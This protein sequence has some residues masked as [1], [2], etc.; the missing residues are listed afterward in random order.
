MASKFTISEVYQDESNR[1]Q[2][3]NSNPIKDDTLMLVS[4][5][6][7]GTYKTKALD[8]G[9][10][11]SSLCASLGIENIINNTTI[12]NYGDTIGISGDYP[13]FFEMY[14]S[15]HFNSVGEACDFSQTDV[16]Q[17][18]GE[19]KGLYGKAWS[20]DNLWTS[21]GQDDTLANRV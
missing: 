21:V 14:S 1:I 5:N 6:D 17:D 19:T 8:Y 7:N 4:E 18:S 16:D 3:D 12:N 11:Q 15:Y 13:C 2:A 20:G 9:T 10:L